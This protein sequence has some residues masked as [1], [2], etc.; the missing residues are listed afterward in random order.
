MFESLNSSLDPAV[1]PWA[2]SVV[3]VVIPK[4]GPATVFTWT[5]GPKLR[6]YCPE[7]ISISPAVIATATLFFSGIEAIL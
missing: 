1:N 6:A 7:W 2:K 4:T 5:E 3:K